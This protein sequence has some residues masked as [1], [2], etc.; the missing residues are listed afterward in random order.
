MYK[1]ICER[2]NK[3]KRNIKRIIS[4]LLTITMSVSVAASFS[5]CDNGTATSG[6]STV[7]GG[8]SGDN[9]GSDNN[10]ENT[11]PLSNPVA[12]DENGE[13]DM[14]VALAYQT[15]VDKL[16]AELEAQ[17]VDGSKPVS[18]NA[19]EETVALFNYLKSIYGK[20]TLAGQQYSNEKEYEDLVYV[21]ETGDLPAL[22]GFD[23][24][25]STGSQAM[26]DR[27][28]DDAILWHTE[29][30][31]IVAMC[32]HWKVPVSMSDEN[33][34]GTAFYTDEIKDFSLEKA[35]TPGTPEYEIIIKDI[36][37]A[38][39]KLQRL[40]AAGVPVLWRPL[41]EASGSWFWWG[42][43]SKE[44][45]EK[46]LYQKLWYMIY[47]RFE[48]YHKLTNIIWVWNGQAKKAEVNANTY[49][50]AGIDVYPN[51]EDH[52]A[53]TS[54]YKTLEKISDES[55]M[56]ALTE[57]GYIPDPDEIYAA[58]SEVKWLYYMPWNNE[59]ICAVT[60]SGAI[61]TNIDGTPSLNP[62]RASS[63]FLK[64]VYADDR[65]ITLSKLPDFEGTTKKI[66]DHI[67]TWM[68]GV[69]DFNIEDTKLKDY[70][71]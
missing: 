14:K 55:K 53:L 17:T 41:H 27:M 52:S 51:T 50:I 48:N 44:V 25:F 59:F 36:D 10:G 67:K 66:P 32:W 9:S 24:I 63:D 30:N 40:E 2:I 64:K 60:G 45:L 46:Q 15:D 47:D 13:V 28:V 12:L 54:S 56:L 65:I 33:I 34:V 1:L 61:I 38:A 5:A 4:A 29:Q 31:G 23:L 49:D 43:S 3:M 58:D 37:T 22:K 68:F 71:K 42:V 19:N 11:K 39:L 7:S 35:V 6:D 21:T 70:E 57:C 18:K 8:E 26:N 16:V 20:Q 69:K 62:D